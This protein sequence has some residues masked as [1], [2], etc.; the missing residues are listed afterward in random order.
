MDTFISYALFMRDNQRNSWIKTSALEIC[1]TL[2]KDF[3]AGKE[4][5][6]SF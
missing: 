2:C 4:V 1:D 6:Y 3:L 5:F